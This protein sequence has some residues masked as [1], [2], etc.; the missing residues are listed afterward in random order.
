MAE[1]IGDFE[2]RLPMP[3]AETGVA[4]DLFTNSHL[5]P[6]EGASSTDVDAAEL[7]AD[8]RL[9]VGG[10]VAEGARRKLPPPDAAGGDGKRAAGR[11][12]RPSLTSA[13]DGAAEEC[14][15]L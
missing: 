13:P 2:Q 10:N 15:L 12:V 4:Y 14:V 3:T 9:A 11:R 7:P 6:R 1:W 8:G 5:C